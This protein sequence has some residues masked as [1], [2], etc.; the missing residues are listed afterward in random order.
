MVVKCSDP[1]Q[2]SQF[3]P[4]LA[5]AYQQTTYHPPRY[6]SGYKHCHTAGSPSGDSKS[7]EGFDTAKLTTTTGIPIPDSR[8]IPDG[9]W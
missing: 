7:D 8:L 2:L 3:T 6:K 4:A 1:G 9:K 5:P